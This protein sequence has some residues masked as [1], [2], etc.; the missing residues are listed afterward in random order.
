MR[1]G[2]AW[3]TAFVSLA[4]TA[5]V[6]VVGCSVVNSFGSLAPQRDRGAIVVGGVVTTAGGDAYVLTALDPLTGEELPSA[7]RT[8][9]VAG[10]YYDG[11][12]D[13]WYVFESGVQSHFFPLPTD[14]FYV[15]VMQL[16]PVTG[17]WT[18]LAAKAIPPAV[19]FSTTAVLN[20][21]LAY[22]AY[23]NGRS[24]E[25]NL[26]V[27]DTSVPAA[28]HETDEVAIASPPVALVGLRGSSSSE[29][30]RVVLCATS[31]PRPDNGHH[32]NRRGYPGRDGCG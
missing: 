3:T 15:H 1:R 16:D 18:E 31:A 13:L 29:T 8:M 14:P 12:R 25:F 6:P 20:E 2:L 23:A 5:A 32:D 10:V 7:R 11:T 9:T 4:A 26:V 21:R 22:I 28:I 17:T 30:Q 27:L 24:D 19:S